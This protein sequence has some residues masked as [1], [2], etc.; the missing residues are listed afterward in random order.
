MNDCG[1]VRRGLVWRAKVWCGRFGEVSLERPGAIRAFLLAALGAELSINVRIR[2]TMPIFFNSLLTQVGLTLPD[3]R[4]LR[5][6]DTRADKGKS[7]YELWRDDR[8]KFDQYQSVQER[9]RREHLKAQYWASFVGQTDSQTLFVG[10]FSVKYTGPLKRD[11][12]RICTSGMDRPATHDFYELS[13][14]DRLREFIGKL[15]ISWGEGARSWIQRPDNQNKV[16]A[17]LRPEEKEP[18]FPGF[19]KFISNLSK[20]EADVLP[21]QWKDILE[22]SRG[23]YL[24]T[25]PKTKEQYVGS[26]YGEGGFWGRW[27]VHAKTGGYGDAVKLKSRDPSDYQVTILEVVGTSTTNDEIIQIE[28]QWKEK[29]RTKEMGL[30]GN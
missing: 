3:V 27:Q 1:W 21:K 7:P 16:I 13:L 11:T 20:I 12:P 29:L 28:K 8:A 23:V 2:R 15:F 5:H 24:L 18:E 25:C 10:L 17:E 4:L 6:Q 19:L 30:N 14:D 9:V 22:I 26:A